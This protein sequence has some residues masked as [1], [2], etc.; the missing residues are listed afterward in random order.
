MG[1]GHQPCEKPLEPTVCFRP[2]TPFPCPFVQPYPTTPRTCINRD[3]TRRRFLRRTDLDHCD[4]T[5]QFCQAR[6][7][8][9][10]IIPRC[11]LLEVRPRDSYV[12]PVAIMCRRVACY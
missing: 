4:A 1:G 12:S 8:G 9:L 3:H 2:H 5:N 10:A 6:V 7:E 11:G